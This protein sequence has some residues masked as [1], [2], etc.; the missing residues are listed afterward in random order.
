MK[1]NLTS[2]TIFLLLSIGLIFIAL[3]SPS[4]ASNQFDD[5][6]FFIKRQILWV[7]L[8]V[9][10]YFIISRLK[11]SL[12][13]KLI[14]AFYWFSVAFLLL[15][16]LPPLSQKVLGAR[17]WLE[18]GSLTI[19]PAEIF[20]LSSILFFARLL[21]RPHPHPLT[22]LLLYLLPPLLLIIL[23]PNL[24][25][26]II[27]ALVIISLYYLSGAPII[28]LFLISLFT[29]TLSLLLIFTSSYRLD[30]LQALIH[31][32]TLAP[33][34]SYHSRQIILALASGG[35][36][37]KGLANSEQKFRFLPKIPTDSILAIIGEET[38]FLGIL[39][40]ICLYPYLVA[41]IFKLA[42]RLQDNFE[43]LL[44]V[45]IGCWLGYQSLVNISSLA[46]L[47][48]LTGVPLPLISYGGSSVIT[49]LAGLGLV[50]N[51]ELQHG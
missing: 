16:L 44:V 7:A 39:L 28:P 19:Q 40:I 2:I 49:L 15:V 36:F 1:K 37:G 33:A 50:R 27:I 38:G 12:I 10:L 6:F 26:A 43:T 51:L 21:S 35:A 18:I 13:K 20:K 5:Q 25:T 48:P 24:S 30:R 42:T 22:S 31:P 32:T 46:T 41:R 9:I 11:L 45:G 8:G 23:Q 29:A 47:I 34:L 4:E 17:R 3:A 14:P